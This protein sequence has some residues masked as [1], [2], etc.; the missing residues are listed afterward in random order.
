MYNI[1]MGRTKKDT[2]ALEQMC[3]RLV[4]LVERHLRMKWA[5]VAKKL[6]YAGATTVAKAKQ[7]KAFPDV[8][9]LSSL[10]EIRTPSG[11]RPNLH[12][13][14]TGEGSPL[15]AARAPHGPNQ[16]RVTVERIVRKLDPEKIKALERLLD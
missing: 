11:A 1:H 16:I 6:G 3:D 9:R 5:E 12:W 15:L 13:L 14:L 8:E 10:A 7:H 2:A 4:E